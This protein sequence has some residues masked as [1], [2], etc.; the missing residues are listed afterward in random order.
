[1]SRAALSDMADFTLH[2]LILLK[3]ALITFWHRP[4]SMIILL[5][6]LALGFW[7]GLLSERHRQR[8]YEMQNRGELLLRGAVA[9]HFAPPDYHLMNHLT[10]RCEDGTTQIDH[11]LVSRFGIFVIETKDYKGWIFGTANQ[12]HWTQVLFR[13]KHRFQNPLFQNYKHVLAVRQ[14]L[15]F[16]P[17]ETIKSLIVFVGSAELKT[18]PAGV[19]K[20]PELLDYL[21]AQTTELIS[22]NRMQFCIG[23]LE[24]TRLAI[25]G[26]TDIQHVERLHQRLGGRLKRRA[27]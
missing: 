27:R 14:T 4:D 15:D 1:M 6:A 19:F 21:H 16:L 3:K 17:P 13:R 10:L 24:T 9:T 2:H 26:E 7:L 18:Q 22:L 8:R 5:A 25:S 23:R 20:L 11:I 12:A